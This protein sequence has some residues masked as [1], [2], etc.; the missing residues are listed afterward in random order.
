MSRDLE[1][2]RLLKAVGE[3]H[4]PSW[5]TTEMREEWD[6][7]AETI[8]DDDELDQTKILI[9]ELII[10]SGRIKEAIAYLIHGDFPLWLRVLELLHAASPRAA[11][12]CLTPSPAEVRHHHEHIGEIVDW[13]VEH[14]PANHLVLVDLME[15]CDF[16]LYAVETVV[17]RAPETLMYLQDWSTD[18]SDRAMAELFILHGAGHKL[19][20]DVLALEGLDRY[21]KECR[22]WDYVAQTPNANGWPLVMG[23]FPVPAFELAF[24]GSGRRVEKYIETRDPAYRQEYEGH[25]DFMLH[26]YDDPKPACP[27]ANPELLA[28]AGVGDE[29]L[30]AVIDGADPVRAF[31]AHAYLLGESRVWYPKLTNLAKEHSEAIIDAVAKNWAWYPAVV[32]LA[33][34]VISEELQQTLVSALLAAGAVAMIPQLATRGSFMTQEV[35]EAIHAMDPRVLLLC[36]YKQCHFKP[37]LCAEWFLN[38]ISAEHSRLFSRLLSALK[39]ESGAVRT[40]AA[41]VPHVLAHVENWSIKTRDVSTMELLIELG[42]AHKLHPR[43]LLREGFGQYH[44]EA[45]LAEWRAANEPLFWEDDPSDWFDL[46]VAYGYDHTPATLPHCDGAERYIQFRGPEYRAEAEAFRALWD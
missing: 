26:R 27:P 16:D 34:K 23:G 38:N 11:L 10:T 35:I 25:Q 7:T 21:G 46:A 45:R 40:V 9:M 20:P 42:A 22:L 39:W 2:A 8:E 24:W 43:F 14:Y 19:R 4:A 37:D 3:T 1:L 12:L 15:A 13:V 36:L 28:L 33:A 18:V 17:N 6:Q 31:F 5:F 29:E 44:E 41:R 32:K 30:L